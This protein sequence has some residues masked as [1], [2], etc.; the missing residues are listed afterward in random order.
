MN[1]LNAARRAGGRM[2]T[3]R[4]RTG[5]IRTGVAAACV[6]AALTMGACNND[7]GASDDTKET[8]T[9]GSRGGSGG[10]SGGGAGTGKPAPVSGPKAEYVELYEQG[11]FQRAKVAAEDAAAA[12]KGAARDQALVVAGMLRDARPAK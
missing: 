2:R 3:G 8:R 10:G 5:W 11:H 7:K 1:G 6:L 9:T 4:I 12:S